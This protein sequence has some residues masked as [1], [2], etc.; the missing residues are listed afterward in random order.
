[1]TSEISDN[2]MSPSGAAYPHLN[3]NMVVQTISHELHYKGVKHKD[4]VYKMSS[5]ITPRTWR[6]VLPYI[7][8]W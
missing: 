4:I 5:Q 1:M 6:H 3:L 2:T 8:F 7:S